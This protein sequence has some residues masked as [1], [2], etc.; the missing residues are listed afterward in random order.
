MANFGTISSNENRSEYTVLKA[1]WYHAEIIN[2][3]F[4]PSNSNPNNQY[5]EFTFKIVEG[6]SINRQVRS[7]FNIINQRADAARIAKQQLISLADAVGIEDPSETDDFIGRHCRIKVSIRPGD[8]KYAESNE[9]KDY[10]PY[11]GTVT[12]SAPSAAPAAAA[13]SARKPAWL[14]K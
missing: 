14:N 11:D 13:P 7:R 6:E 8:D 2:G 10:K 9:V 4:K 12:P 3:D 1:G 5:V